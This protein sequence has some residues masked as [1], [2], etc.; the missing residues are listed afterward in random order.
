MFWEVETK[1]SITDG[2][3]RP[4]GAVSDITTMKNLILLARLVMKKFLYAYIAFLALKNSP[5]KMVVNSRALCW[6]VEDS[7]WT[8]AA[9]KILRRFRS[10]DKLNN[11][12]EMHGD[13]S[14]AFRIS[15]KWSFTNFCALNFT[16]CYAF[17]HSSLLLVKCIRLSNGY[18]RISVKYNI[19]KTAEK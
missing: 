10:L 8:F 5:N 13:V 7:D 3:G 11:R 14:D 19:F 18:C 16:W 2:F 4:C 9:W 6:H 17:I 1:T 12:C 15:I